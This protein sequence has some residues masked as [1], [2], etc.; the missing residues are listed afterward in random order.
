[1]GDAASDL[2]KAVIPGV[3][4]LGGFRL[5]GAG[6]SGSSHGGGITINGGVTMKI[7][8]SGL[9]EALMARAVEKGM[10]EFRTKL[11]IACRGALTLAELT[12]KAL[13]LRERDGPGGVADG[14][15]DE[16]IVSSIGNLNYH[17]SGE[18]HLIQFANNR[19]L[20]GLADTQQANGCKV[21]LTSIDA[22]G[23][24]ISTHVEMK[25]FG[26]HRAGPCK[27]QVLR[28]AAVIDDLGS[29]LDRGHAGDLGLQCGN[30]RLQRRNPRVRGVLCA[31]R[32]VVKRKRCDGSDGGKSGK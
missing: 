16:T 3:S 1:M 19:N 11:K 5:P 7:E 32:R 17:M 6:S 4:E 10:E 15:G 2:V 14:R 21:I 26:H 23:N 12:T 9:D 13:F 25:K 28:K 20:G 22:D 27:C 31:A 24:I 18:R 30:P 8:G 29:R